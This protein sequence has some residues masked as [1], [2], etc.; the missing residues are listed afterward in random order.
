MKFREG[1]QVVVL[2]MLINGDRRDMGGYVVGQGRGK[3]VRD[4]IEVKVN[5][6]SLYFPEDRLVDY[7][8]YWASRN[9]NEIT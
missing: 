2:N 8:E 9:K 1:Q 3:P 6:V 5:G 7:E 4:K